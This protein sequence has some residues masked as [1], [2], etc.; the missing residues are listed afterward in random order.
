V[1]R[2][3][4]GQL[5]S[6][7]TINMMS[8][9]GIC[10]LVETTGDDVPELVWWWQT[11][12]ETVSVFLSEV[13]V[14]RATARLTNL[15]TL[16][17]DTEENL[18]PNGQW[19]G[20]V[21][22]IG[23][24]DLDSEPG[25]DAI[26]LGVSAG[27]TYDP[28][29]VRLWN[30]RTGEVDWRLPTGGTPT[31]G[32]AAADIDEDG[33]LELLVCLEAPGNNVTAGEWSDLHSYVVAVE[34]DGSVRWWR[35]LGGYSSDVDVAVADLDGNGSPE[36]VTGLSYHSEADAGMPEVTVW[37]GTD[38]V[39]LD[40]L[41][42]GCPV[43]IVATAEC[44]E[45]PRVFAGASDG[46]LMRLR[47]DGSSLQ[48]ERT[49]ECGDAVEAIT[50][51]LLSPVLSET[52]LLVGMSRGE[53]AVVDME[54]R[55]LAVTAVDGTIDG[56]N[57]V[58][59]SEL[60]GED[61][62]V[63]GIL[64]RTSDKTYRLKI[65]TK[66]APLWLRILVPVLAALAVGASIPGTRRSAIA[67]LRRWLMPRQS[68][69]E[70]IEELLSALSTAGHGKLAATSTLRRLHR[71]SATIASGD[72]P[73]TFSERFLDAVGNVTDVG[74][75]GLDE[76]CRLSERVGT[77]PADTARLAS[78]V[79]V[80][81]SLLNDLPDALPS[82]KEAG[83]L[84]KRLNGT[85]STLDASLQ[86]IKSAAERERSSSLGLELERA[87]SARRQEMED[88]GVALEAPSPTALR[89]ARVVGTPREISFVLDNLIG[90]A[91]KAMMERP[92]RRLRI[93]VEFGGGKVSLRVADT[94]K[95]VPASSREL[96]FARGV[97]DREGGGHGLAASRE[98]LAA[99]GGTIELA[100]SAPGEGAVFEVKLRLLQG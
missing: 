44:P 32:R 91:L 56:F 38:G 47:W 25:R 15:R 22:L 26:V 52:C 83:I 24:L 68:R 59:P 2:V 7:D 5:Y 62:P 90:N 18:L 73:E 55:P 69:D 77:A 75:P 70:S 93:S 99:R 74:L 84:E 57:R 13:V 40:T 8:K 28:R 27:I 23:S 36:V 80:L 97:S 21:F 65:V 71:Q 11:A 51:A 39:L 30:I 60:P 48:Q 14:D 37:R 10:G 98:M 76:I 85:L 61:G 96:I 34:L 41:S 82:A 66:P 1:A 19:G 87:L 63:T 29:E 4:T 94:G 53:V 31:G 58:R 17:V 43:N 45:G 42:V 46:R 20:D 33:D 50:S 64:V 49:L 67:L 86:G 12:R 92:E 81:R 16:V 89:S 100:E 54:L 35:E 72:V 6:L 78:D 79:S 95:G 3:G 9:G 88:M